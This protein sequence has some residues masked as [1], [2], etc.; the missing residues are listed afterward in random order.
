MYIPFSYFTTG[1]INATG[2]D[3]VTYISGSF[4]YK[5]HEFKGTPLPFEFKILSGQT[6]DAEI[7]LV[8][9]GGSAGRIG[10][11]KP[12]DI[13]WHGGGGGAGGFIYSQSLNLSVGTYTVIPANPYGNPQLEG[14]N[15][16]DSSFVGGGYNIVAIGGG[17]GGGYNSLTSQSLAPG[18]GGSG[19]GASGQQFGGTGIVG[20]GTN[21]GQGQYLCQIGLFNDAYQPGGGGGAAGGGSRYTTSGSIQLMGKGGLGKISRIKNGSTIWYAGGAAGVPIHLCGNNLTRPTQKQIIEATPFGGKIG[22]LQ[23]GTPVSANPATS[24]MGVLQNT[25]TAGGGYSTEN[26]DTSAGTVIVAYKLE[27]IDVNNCECY[28]FRASGSVSIKPVIS[29]VECGTGNFIEGEAILPN[30]SVYRSVVSGS[31]VPTTTTVANNSQLRIWEGNVSGAISLS[32]TKVDNSFC[33]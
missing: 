15:G 28:E 5:S 13:I 16:K 14:A 25:Y 29:Y 24:S 26:T 4:R 20:Q 32:L 33:S 11:Q 22:A 3:I 8:A 31:G 21:G 2:G 7:L 9:G 10:T 18:N 23:D 19:G 17:R 12:Q 30:T 1:K 27:P 6:T